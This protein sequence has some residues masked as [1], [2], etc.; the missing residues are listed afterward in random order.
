MRFD[1][2]S[3]GEEESLPGLHVHGFRSA[4]PLFSDKACQI[5]EDANLLDNLC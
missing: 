4:T 1:G 5:W 2:I 3:K